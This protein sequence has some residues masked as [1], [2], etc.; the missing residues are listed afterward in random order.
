[1]IDLTDT[2]SIYTIADWVELKVLY[3]NRQF[4]KSR[5]FSLLK[6]F[7]D[8]I[9]ETTIDSVMNEL[10][11]RSELYGDAS[12]FV[13]ERK[14]V[15]PRL[16]WRDRPELVMCLIFSI[17]GVVRK[18]G[19]NDG[20]KLFEILSGEAVKSYLNGEAEVIGFPNQT[21]L[22]QQIEGISRRTCEKLGTRIPCPRDKDK[23]VDI[24]AW[25][26]HGDKRSNQVVLL[27]QCGTGMHFAQKKSISL[28]AWRD[29]VNW[30]V[31]P[32]KGI[33]IPI[34]P[35]EEQWIKITD[36]YNLI[37][38]RVRIYRAIYNRSFSDCQLRRR[39]LNWCRLQLN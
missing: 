2:A 15:I 19:R 12:P 20:T 34:I 14:S 29:F 10:T 11:R 4:S 16:R 3:H 24:I 17:R 33:M 39:I 28:H 8:T 31:E 18:R 23:G 1:M 38:D 36:D 9:E 35:S 5:I 32:I 30:S 7:D 22:R 25:K 13:V 21:R 37:F 26:P 27:L 6:A